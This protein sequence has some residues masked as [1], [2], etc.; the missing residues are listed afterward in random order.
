MSEFDKFIQAVENEE[1]TGRGLL[2]ASLEHR[3]ALRI[4][5]EAGQKAP[6]DLHVAICGSLYR[7]GSDG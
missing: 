2:A 6:K 3:T 1:I 7:L 4:A 5:F